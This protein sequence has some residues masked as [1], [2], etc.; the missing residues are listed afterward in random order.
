MFDVNSIDAIYVSAH[1]FNSP[2]IYYRGEICPK[3][4]DIDEKTTMDNSIDY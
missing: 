2:I 1:H 4:G 3:G